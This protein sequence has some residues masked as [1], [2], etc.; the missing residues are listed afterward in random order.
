VGDELD[1]VGCCLFLRYGLV[2]IERVV[3]LDVYLLCYKG[4]WFLNLS[5]LTVNSFTITEKMGL[6]HLWSDKMQFGFG[7]A[8]GFVELCCCVLYAT[9]Q[10]GF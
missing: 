4:Y 10:F 2:L 8:I 5:V 1:R 6:A 7:P 9:I 3:E